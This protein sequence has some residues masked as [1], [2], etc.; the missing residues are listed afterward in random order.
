[1]SFRIEEN[2]RSLTH[3]LNQLSLRERTFWSAFMFLLR[4][5]KS[6]EIFFLKKEFREKISLHI[7]L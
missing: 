7:Y 3:T 4:H 2:L 1:M 5:T 6:T